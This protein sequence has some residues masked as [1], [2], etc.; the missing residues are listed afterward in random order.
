MTTTWQSEWEIFFVKLD[1]KYSKQF[2]VFPTVVKD[3]VKL[4]IEIIARKMTLC[5]RHQLLVKNHF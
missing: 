5:N 4:F 3:A 1:T 2:S